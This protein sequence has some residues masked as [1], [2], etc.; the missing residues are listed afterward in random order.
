MSDWKSI[1]VV[2]IHGQVSWHDEAWVVGNVEGLRKLRDAIDGAISARVASAG[3]V[4]SDGECY[5]IIVQRAD[6]DDA[7]LP[8]TTDYAQ[9]GGVSPW[10]RMKDA[11]WRKVEGEA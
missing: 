6:M 7:A 8:Y 11:D 10:E 4:A 9:R 2:H 3:V 1:G 5:R